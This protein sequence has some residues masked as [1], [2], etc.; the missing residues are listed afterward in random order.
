MYCLK[1][2]LSARVSFAFNFRCVYSFLSI[3]YG[4]YCNVVHK[5][6]LKR[7]SSALRQSANMYDCQHLFG[8]K[9]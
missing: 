7:V 4:S 9:A 5:I 8:K 2:M 6:R 3:S 1:N